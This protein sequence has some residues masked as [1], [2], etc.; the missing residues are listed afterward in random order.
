MIHD[1]PQ[2]VLDAIQSC[3]FG[4]EAHT[5]QSRS[6][7]NRAIQTKVLQGA[8]W[9]GSF[10]FAKCTRDEFE[11][12][13]TFLTLLGGR[14]GRFNAM[15][16]NATKPRGAATGNGYVNAAGQTG[17]RLTTSGWDA[18]ST[19]LKAGDYI[20]VGNEYKKVTQDVLSDGS[21]N[22]TITFAP[23]LRTSPQNNEIVVAQN[24]KCIVQL[25]DDRQA[26]APIAVDGTYENI[27]ISFVEAFSL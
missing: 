1:I 16:L 21:G 3:T 22:A 14:E 5:R 11:N 8:R 27:T 2:A 7:F 13:F 9:K 23:T 10:T 26:M 20:Q 25:V 24:P 18:N 4:F 17:S 19:I 15:D 12:I 6:P